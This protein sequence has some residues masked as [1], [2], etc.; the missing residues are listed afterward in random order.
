M[1]KKQCF[2][3]L[4]RFKIQAADSTCCFKVKGWSN[5]IM[6]R[7]FSRCV[8]LRSTSPQRWFSA[9]ATGSQ[10][11]GGRWASS[12][13]SSWW[14]ACHFLETL[15]RSCSDRSSQVRQKEQQARQKSR[16][17]KYYAVL[18]TSLPLCSPLS[19]S[20]SAEGR[21]HR[22]ARGRRGSPTRCPAPDLLPLANQS[23]GS[24]WHRWDSCFGV[25]FSGDLIL[26]AVSC[27]SGDAAPLRC[28]HHGDIKV[29]CFRG[30]PPAL[31]VFLCV[32]PCFSPQKW[33]TLGHILFSPN[34]GPISNEF[35]LIIH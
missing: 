11:T 24:T 28:P 19:P 35:K 16:H 34:F 3:C 25:H 18:V 13:M 4:K 12:F 30:C 29:F 6:G 27:C 2:S 26:T 22:V 5:I 1:T 14:A 7:L 15:P 8:E 20:S 17:R 10:W 9:R 32:W 23:P 31:Y 33:V 21:W